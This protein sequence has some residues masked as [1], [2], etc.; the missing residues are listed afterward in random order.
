[1][2][3]AGQ[4]N[5]TTEKDFMTAAGRSLITAAAPPAPPPPSLV[6]PGISL[7]FQS[8]SPG[9]SPRLEAKGPVYDFFS[10]FQKDPMG[11]MGDKALKSKS[12]APFLALLPPAP[13]D[14]S[15]DLPAAR[16]PLEPPSL[17]RKQTAA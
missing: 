15:K 17:L 11:E 5:G 9:G 14:T 10:F 8:L 2:E 7:C 6:Q 13:P 4:V 3:P 1:M 16:G 12:L